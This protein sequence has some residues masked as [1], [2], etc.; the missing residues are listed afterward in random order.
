MI[1]CNQC[2]APLKDG[3]RFCNECGAAVPGTQPLDTHALEETLVR[4]PR[5]E[6]K[7]AEVI[8]TQRLDK[9]RP[10]ASVAVPVVVLGVLLGG[11]FL[12]LLG[13]SSSRSDSYNSYNSYNAS[14]SYNSTNSYNSNANYS[15]NTGNMNSN[16]GNVNG[17]Y[18]SNTNAGGYTPSS[19][20]MARSGFDYVESKILNDSYISS[21][22]LNGLSLWQ[23]RLLRNT[24]FA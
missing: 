9:G 10:R 11:G 4:P 24:V 15:T 12:L 17:G 3:A 7:G 19:T 21:S 5:Q 16:R 18:T 23:L 13:I 2:G 6:T 1:I 14:S 22:D 20:P 8:D